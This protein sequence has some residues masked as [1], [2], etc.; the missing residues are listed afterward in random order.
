MHPMKSWIMTLAFAGILGS[1]AAALSF[2]LRKPSQD[3]EASTQETERARNMFRALA[4]R[5]ALSVLLFLCV[6][7]A[8]KMGWIRPSGLPIG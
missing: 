2:M 5:V 3:T 1:L 6:L 4:M 8:W 7:L